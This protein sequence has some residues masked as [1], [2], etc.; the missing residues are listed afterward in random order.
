MNDQSTQAAVPRSYRK[1]LRRYRASF[2][3]NLRRRRGKRKA[4]ER[5]ADDRDNF[6]AS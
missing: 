3:E 1:R 4:V 5:R 6:E 2:F